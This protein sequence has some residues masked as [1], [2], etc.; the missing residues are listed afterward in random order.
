MIHCR[1]KH[2]C[3]MYIYGK[4]IKF[5]YKL[6]RLASADEYTYAFDIHIYWKNKSRSPGWVG[7]IVNLN[8]KKF[9]SATQSQFLIYFSLSRKPN[10]KKVKSRYLKSRL[11]TPKND[12]HFY[13]KP[14][15]KFIL[16]R[17]IIYFS[18]VFVYM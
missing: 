5:E 11:V 1:G 6:W 17:V 18:Q 8:I 10:A 2:T 7:T 4:P 3:K 9:F 16:L 13:G 14:T 15:G 12:W